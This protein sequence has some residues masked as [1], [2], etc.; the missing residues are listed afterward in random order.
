V[1]MVQGDQD[2]LVPVEAAREVAR[3]NPGWR[4]VELVGVGH[5]PQLQVPKVLATEVLT[6][7]DAVA[8]TRSPV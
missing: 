2:R 3:R 4:Y 5:V 1:L 7:L 6:W 8:G